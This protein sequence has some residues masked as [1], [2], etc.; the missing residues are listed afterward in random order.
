MK[1][2]TFRQF[3]FVLPAQY[4]EE[5][6]ARDVCPGCEARHSAEGDQ[7]VKSCLWRGEN[8]EITNRRLGRL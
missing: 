1:L 7:P 5:P 8:G 6:D 2:C 3:A 4:G